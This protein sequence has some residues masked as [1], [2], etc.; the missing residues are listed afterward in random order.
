M[1]DVNV[2]INSR[3]LYHKMTK[4]TS[5]CINIKGTHVY[6][7]DRVKFNIYISNVLHLEYLQII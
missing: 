2:M 1:N 4:I 6:T 5:R 3:L 7:C